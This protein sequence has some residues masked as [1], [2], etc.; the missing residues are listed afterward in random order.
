MLV[1]SR[2]QR[3]LWEKANGVHVTAA[4]LAALRQRPELDWVSA[5]VHSGAEIDRAAEL[6]LDFVAAGPV[7]ITATHR[8]QPSL[9]WNAFAEMITCSSVPVYALGGMQQRD[10][11][12]AM[13]YGAHGIASLSAVWNDA[14][15]DRLDTSGVLLGSE[16]SGPAI[17]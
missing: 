8:H 11:A 6:N 2:H 12:T 5:S 17:E 9:G 14:Q 15:C 10:L 1:N 4:D 7:W 16:S 13:T 3:A